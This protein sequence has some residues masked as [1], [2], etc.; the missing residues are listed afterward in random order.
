V[1]PGEHP[2]RLRAE[3]ADLLQEEDPHRPLDSLEAVVVHSYL[4]RHGVGAGAP[5]ADRPRTIE[6]WVTWAVRH[7][8]DS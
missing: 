8:R 5:A 6:G 3:L 2:E 4:H 1:S 7:S